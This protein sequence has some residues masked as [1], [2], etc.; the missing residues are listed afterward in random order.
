MKLKQILNNR[1]GFTLMELIVVLIIIAVLMAALLPSLIGWINE[2]RESALRVDG[3]TALLAAQSV[4]TEAKGT[5]Y[6]NRPV[7][8]E[9]TG[10]VTRALISADFKFQTLMQDA[11]LYG[12]TVTPAFFDNPFNRVL[13]ATGIRAVYIDTDQNVIGLVIN[14]TVRQ[15]RDID[16][17]GGA[18]GIGGLLVGERG[19]VAG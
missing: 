4:V 8:T 7:T 11:A 17:L 15:N 14:N 16:G 6:W 3:R 9:Y 12:S 1:K 19:T 5:G 18:L 2:S 13:P 10:V